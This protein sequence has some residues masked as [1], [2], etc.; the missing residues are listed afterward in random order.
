MLVCMT[1]VCLG[2]VAD[3]FVHCVCLMLTGGWAMGHDSCSAVCVRP[4]RVCTEH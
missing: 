4:W 2:N 3:D 1:E